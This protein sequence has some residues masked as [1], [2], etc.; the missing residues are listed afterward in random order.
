MAFNPLDPDEQPN[1]VPQD[2]KVSVR[3]TTYNHAPYIRQAIEGVLMQQTDFNFELCIGEDDSTDG[4]RE[5]CK[6]YAAKYPDKVRLFLRQKKDKIYV[7]GRM[8]GKYNSRQTLKACRGKYIAALE[9][10]DFWIDPKKLQIQFD[11]MEANPGLMMC[12]TRCLHWRASGDGGGYVMPEAKYGTWIGRNKI[13]LT[14]AYCHTSTHFVR[15]AHYESSERWVPNVIQGDLAF[16]LNMARIQN[17]I[18]VLTRVTSVYRKS[19]TGIWTG[20]SRLEL[21]HA[22]AGFWDEVRQRGEQLGD[23]NWIR[24]G[25]RHSAFYSFRARYGFGKFRRLYKFVAFLLFPKI[26]LDVAKETCRRAILRRLS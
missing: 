6:E 20:A 8:T 2:V 11:F 16:L 26:G 25:K 4:T 7:N 21:Q 23:E 24:M 17:G 22:W 10:D 13:H 9:G 5:I 15:A 12:G 14:G 3:I 19:G 18:P 1:N